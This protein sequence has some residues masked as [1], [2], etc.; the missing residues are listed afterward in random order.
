MSVTRRTPHPIYGLTYELQ[1]FVCRTCQDEITRS[2]D[3]HG[4]PHAYDLAG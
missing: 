3:G 2:A 4:L 1:T